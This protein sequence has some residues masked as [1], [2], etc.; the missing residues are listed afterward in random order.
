[1]DSNN[2]LPDY[3]LYKISSLI[4]ILLSAYAAIPK[5]SN[6]QYQDA[7]P[8]LLQSANDAKSR[9][10][11]LIADRDRLR[12]LVIRPSANAQTTT[13]TQPKPLLFYPQ[14]TL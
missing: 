7:K 14:I 8:H 2:D 13:N 4:D 3:D 5:M 10:A 6:Q 9:V 12:E 1:M 11:D